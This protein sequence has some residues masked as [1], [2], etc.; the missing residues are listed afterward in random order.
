MAGARPLL[1]IGRGIKAQGA[2]PCRGGRA[3]G[4]GQGTHGGACV[5]QRCSCRSTCAASRRRL[6]V[7][8]HPS[9]R[10]GSG[11]HSRGTLA[12]RSTSPAPVVLGFPPSAVHILFRARPAV[13]SAY[14]ANSTFVI[15]PDALAGFAAA[16][17]VPQYVAGV[18]GVED[19]KRSFP[20]LREDES[21]PGEDE[22]IPSLDSNH[23]CTCKS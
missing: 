21:I 11:S 15:R 23:T 8:W 1:R 17:L 4:G 22:S 7:R 20:P 19:E 2:G 14:D 6:V 10:G 12:T 5:G 18:R 9:T 16:L 13:Q 3:L